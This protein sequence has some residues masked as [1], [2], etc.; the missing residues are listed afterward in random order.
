MA[1][2]ARPAPPSGNYSA[3]RIVIADSHAL[4]RTALKRL[5][6]AES[7]FQV[8]AEAEDGVQAVAVVRQMQPQVLLL[9]LKLPRCSGLDALREIRKASP[10]T[11]S[12]LLV[13]DI[14]DEQLIEALR[15]GARGV[16]FKTTGTNLLFKSIRAVVAGEYWLE[17]NRIAFLIQTLNQRL[18]A[19]EKGNGHNLFGLVPRELEVVAAIAN[20]LSTRDM[21]ANFGLSEITVRHQLTQVYRKLQVRN[22]AEL[23]SFAL[24]HNLGDNG[25]YHD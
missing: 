8:I 19:R 23:L 15:L 10:P 24:R 11:L 2:P 4:F 18:Q 6:R 7:D 13:D 21:A 1:M 14:D 16:A 5:L 22:R 9:D 20:G 17:R 3:V 12:L 25:N